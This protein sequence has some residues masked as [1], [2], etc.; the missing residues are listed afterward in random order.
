MLQFKNGFHFFWKFKLKGIEEPLFLIFC[1][2][3]S[4]KSSLLERAKKR[5]ADEEQKAAA[6]VETKDERDYD[7]DDTNGVVEDNDNFFL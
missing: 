6:K 4:F 1:L 3:F 7:D 2:Y 5:K